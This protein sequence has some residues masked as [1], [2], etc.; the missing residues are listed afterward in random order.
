MGYVDNTLIPGEHVTFRTKLHPVLFA[1]PILAFVLG[2]YIGNRGGDDAHAWGGFFILFALIFGLL[3]LLNF[4]TSEFAVTNKR[5]IIKVGA[6]RRRTLELQLA[7]VETVAVTQG[8]LGRIL[9][10]GDVVV[11]GT[12]GTKEPFKNVSS[13]LE[14]RK[15]V[16]SEPVQPAVAPTS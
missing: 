9:G 6:L 2:I 13:A 8:L 3:R 5:V 12:G 11:T 1:A 4:L 10:Y 16:Q 7:K 15:A 14:L